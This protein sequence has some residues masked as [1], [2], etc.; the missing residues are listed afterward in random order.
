M[1][2]ACSSW[3]NTHGAGQGNQ[4][5]RSVPAPH[6]GGARANQASL[7]TLPPWASSLSITGPCTTAG[8]DAKLVARTSMPAPGTI[9]S[10][11]YSRMD[12]VGTDTT[13]FHRK[14]STFKFLWSYVR[15][16]DL[17]PLI[18]VK[19]STIW[20]II[21]WNTSRDSLKSLIR[22]YYIGTFRMD[23][24]F[25]YNNIG[26][27]FLREGKKQDQTSREITMSPRLYTPI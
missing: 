18:S 8:P 26:W 3:T 25:I 4:D 17:L 15:Y 24:F 23:I 10:P 19:K 11:L 5:P 22:W 13:S 6:L 12:Q 2:V 1:Q 20:I 7:S 27:T 21:K 16:Y 14:D 9:L